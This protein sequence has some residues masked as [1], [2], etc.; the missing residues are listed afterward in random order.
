MRSWPLKLLMPM[1]LAKSFATSFS[2]AV[3][4]SWIVALPGTTFLPS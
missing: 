2:M 3:Q 1:D 4:V